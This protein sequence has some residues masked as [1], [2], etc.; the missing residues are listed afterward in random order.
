MAFH[1]AFTNDPQNPRLEYLSSPPVVAWDDPE[2]LP[3]PPVLQWE[4]GGVDYPLQDANLDKRLAHQENLINQIATQQWRT[5]EDLATVPRIL[6]RVEHVLR[7]NEN[8]TRN[9]WGWA[10]EAKAKAKA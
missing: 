6:R 4:D 10:T 8:W 2:Y 9:I 5:R 3:C 7:A 1:I